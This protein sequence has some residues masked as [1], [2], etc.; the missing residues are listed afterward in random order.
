MFCAPQ[1]SNTNVTTILID[2]AIEACP[3]N[4]IHDLRKKRPTCVHGNAPIKKIGEDVTAGIL[5]RLQGATKI[6]AAK[7]L[8]SLC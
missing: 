6:N 2:N 3:W 4:V 1:R 8:V 5:D 7:T